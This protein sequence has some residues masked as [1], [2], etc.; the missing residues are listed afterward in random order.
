MLGGHLGK[1][2]GSSGGKNGGGEVGGGGRGRGVSIG[3]EKGSSLRANRKYLH[4]L[5]GMR[6][7]AESH[8]LACNWGLRCTQLASPQV[9]DEERRKVVAQISEDY[10]REFIELNVAKGRGRPKANNISAAKDSVKGISENIL[11]QLEVRSMRLGCYHYREVCQWMD[12]EMHKTKANGDWNPERKIDQW[13]QLLLEKLEAKPMAD[14]FLPG[15]KLVRPETAVVATQAASDVV[16]MREL[17][18]DDDAHRERRKQAFVEMQAQQISKGSKVMPLSSN[19]VHELCKVI[20]EVVHENSGKH[21]VPSSSPGSHE[22]LGCPHFRRKNRVLMPC[23]GI[24]SVCRMC[25]FLDQTRVH[26]IR[27]EPVTTVLCMLCS[28]VQ[29]KAQACRKCKTEFG[30]YYCDICGIT[31]DPEGVDP[32]HCHKCG[33]CVPG[34]DFHC[35]LCDKCV[36]GPC[37]EHFSLTHKTCNYQLVAPSLGQ[38]AQIEIIANPQPT[39]QD[40]TDEPVTG[41]F[42]V[43]SHTIPAA[44]K[45]DSGSG[46]M[47]SSEVVMS[48]DFDVSGIPHPSSPGAFEIPP[49][50]AFAAHSNAHA[51]SG[52]DSLPFQGHAGE[53]GDPGPATSPSSSSDTLRRNL[54]GG[55]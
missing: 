42:A 11:L 46:G 30:S 3:V 29:P 12:A 9:V 28:E 43:S 55:D 7:Y 25:H 47:V 33:S 16:D 23:C 8:A 40:R 17:V 49:P 22:V 18:D 32:R 36:P 15:E 41:V 34:T 10:K 2:R 45:Q 52:F 1:S 39:T 31:N 38:N 35:E 48:R 50:S 27:I 19:S 37:E 5:G 14:E 24:F 54:C 20:S 6:K 13:E 44:P 51:S 53:A 4:P 26:D 21:F